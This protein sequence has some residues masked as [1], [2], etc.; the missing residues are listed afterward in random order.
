[1]TFVPCFIW[2]FA[3]A[4]LIDWLAGRPRL[5]AAMASITAAIVGVIANLSLWFA[6]HVFFDQLLQIDDGP[7]Q[8]IVPT[9]GSIQPLPLIIAGIAAVLLVWRGYTLLP[10][11]GICAAIGLLAGLVGLPL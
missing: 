11:L 2:I 6:L 3:G 7:L 1:V 8:M 4:P 10:V 9:F 5:S